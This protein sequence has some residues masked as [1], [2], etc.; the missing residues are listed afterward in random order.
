MAVTKKNIGKYLRRFRE[1]FNLRQR[2]VAE[3]IG[4]HPQLYLKYEKDESS[5]SVN[6]ITSIAGA[7]NV[8]TDYLLGLS[9]SPQ[10]TNFDEKEVKEAFAIRDLWKQLQSI[11]STGQSAG[12][13]P[14][15]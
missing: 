4:V 2:D 3:K 12:Q 13:V 1:T 6:V 11:S 8:T 15:Q 9:D 7:Y 14:A 5:P 10:P